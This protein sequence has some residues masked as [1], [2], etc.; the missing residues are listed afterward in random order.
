MGDCACGGHRDAEPPDPD[1]D[2]VAVEAQ[3]G[4]GRDPA[5]EQHDGVGG[6]AQPSRAQ[7]S[8]A[9]PQ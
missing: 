2:V 5:D 7:A 3:D 6:A 8:E 1:P 9:L 4:V